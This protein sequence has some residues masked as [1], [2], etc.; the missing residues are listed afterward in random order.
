MVT[1]STPRQDDLLRNRNRKRRTAYGYFVVFS[2]SMAFGYQNCSG[3]FSPMN[4]EQSLSLGINESPQF[5]CAN[6]SLTPVLPAIVLS[7]K[8]YHNSLAD[9]FGPSILQSVQAQ[10]ATFLSDSNDADTYQRTT[11]LTSQ[12]IEAYE[13]IAR[14]AGSQSKGFTYN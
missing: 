6:P 14:A 2:M 9:L 3:G 7:K 8:Q 12:R 10:L 13:T 4:A 11:E 5:Q 1:D